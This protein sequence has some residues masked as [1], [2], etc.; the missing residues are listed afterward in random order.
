MI[1]RLLGLCAECGFAM[2]RQHAGTFK[3]QDWGA[4]TCTRL[5]VGWDVNVPVQFYD[6]VGQITIWILAEY[7]SNIKIL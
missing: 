1:S 3:I 2:A 6:A 5:G 7:C 4:I